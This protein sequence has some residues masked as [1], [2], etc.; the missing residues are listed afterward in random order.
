MK[1]QTSSFSQDGQRI[2]RIY[3]S[4]S[5]LWCSLLV[6]FLAMLASKHLWCICF[7]IWWKLL[8]I[9]GPLLH[10]CVNI[11]HYLIPEPK[12]FFLHGMLVTSVQGQVH[13]PNSIPN[14]KPSM[15]ECR[16]SCLTAVWKLTF[17][18]PPI[19]AT[20][21]MEWNDISTESSPHHHQLKS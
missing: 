18:A 2:P 16:G 4:T 19:H 8:G 10:E 3:V 1:L 6:S 9:C 20:Q 14:L 12:W 21:K 5:V 15:Y 17:R 7:W 13:K 11:P